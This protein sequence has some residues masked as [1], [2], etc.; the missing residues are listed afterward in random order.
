MSSR[1]ERDWERAMQAVQGLGST[2]ERQMEKRRRDQM[3]KEL[4]AQ[5]YPDKDINSAAELEMQI[6]LDEAMDQRKH[7]QALTARAQREPVARASTRAP[8]GEDGLTP[9]QREQLAVSRERE[10]R[11][12]SKP[13]G[14]TMEDSPEKLEKD[15]RSRFGLSFSDVDDI[16]KNGATPDPSDPNVLNFT[17]RAGA[18]MTVKKDDLMPF[19]NRGLSIYRSRQNA[20]A[21]P[22]ASAAAITTQPQV[23]PKQDSETY[24]RARD[25]IA[26][27]ADP[28]AVRKRLA[29]AGLD[30]SLL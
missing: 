10:K 15:L 7:R 14:E 18:P 16:M 3:A 30:P 27:G 8:I 11:L 24:Q 5:M 13:R 25:A 28:A 1:A 21:D 20:E 29:D 22:N 19:V 4:A 17:T 23:A 2:L 12:S 9:Y 26:R 6:K